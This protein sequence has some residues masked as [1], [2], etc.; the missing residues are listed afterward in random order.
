MQLFFYLTDSDSCPTTKV[1]SIPGSTAGQT[2]V[3]PLRTQ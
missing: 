2:R 3:K 1:S